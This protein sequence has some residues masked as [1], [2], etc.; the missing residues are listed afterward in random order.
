MINLLL[1]E[2]INRVQTVWAALNLHLRNVSYRLQVQ[3]D[4]A[5]SVLAL[6]GRVLMLQVDRYYLWILILILKC[7]NIISRKLF[8]LYCTSKLAGSIIKSQTFKLVLLICIVLLLNLIMIIL[9]SLSWVFIIG[10]LTLLKLNYFLFG[11]LLNSH[12]LK[13]IKTLFKP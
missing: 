11:L 3:S 9:R 5:T 8:K 1:R 12:L 2:I 6:T 10:H 4:W 7:L 13:I